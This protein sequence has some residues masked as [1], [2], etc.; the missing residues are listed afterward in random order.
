MSFRLKISHV[1][2]IELI[3]NSG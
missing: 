1:L 3:R 2:S